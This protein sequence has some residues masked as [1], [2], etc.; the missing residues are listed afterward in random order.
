MLT[1]QAYYIVTMHENTNAPRI[2]AFRE[3]LLKEAEA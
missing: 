2:A 3:W 1:E